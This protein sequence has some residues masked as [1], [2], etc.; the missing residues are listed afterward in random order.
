MYNTFTPFAVLLDTDLTLFDGE[1]ASA[2]ATAAEGATAETAGAE[3]AAVEQTAGEEQAQQPTMDDL[4]REFRE[5]TKG[6]LKDVYTEETQ[7]LIDRRMKSLHE[8]QA[9]LKSYEP[10]L[11]TLATR[12]GV[13]DPAA[14]ARAVDADSALWAQAAEDAGM[15]VEQY[16]QMQKLQAENA[17]FRAMQQQAQQNEYVNQQVQKWQQEGEALKA[18]IPDF[19]LEN[20]VRNP[21]FVN[22]LENGFPMEFAY[23]ALH[24]DELLK[25]TAEQAQKAAIDNIRAR[26][27]RPKENGAA[28]QAPF[29][30]STKVSDLSRD[31]IIEIMRRAERGENVTL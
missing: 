7:R 5:L 28:G 6:R 31:Q 30:V 26:G 11:Q 24:I 17:R 1:S 15:T 19:D 4:R 14:L 18:K 20:E 23:N 21:S 3:T 29:T 10:L 13:D 22:M 25:S 8:A 12:Y 27:N 9:R 16:M 2:G